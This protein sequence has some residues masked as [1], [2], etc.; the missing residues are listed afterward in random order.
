M[1]RLMAEST[2]A[3]PFTLDLTRDVFRTWVAKHSRFGFTEMNEAAGALDCHFPREPMVICEHVLMKCETGSFEFVA[4]VLRNDGVRS[5]MRWS[6]TCEL[7]SGT[8]S[9]RGLMQD[10]T[11]LR[12]LG[13]RVDGRSKAGV[14]RTSSPGSL[15][16]SNTPV[17][18]VSTT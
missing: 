12:R 2:K 9:L 6:G 7:L 1:F 5:E 17:Q 16:K 8:K 15:T 4:T 11:E 13:P 14:C 3:A 10:I 18:F